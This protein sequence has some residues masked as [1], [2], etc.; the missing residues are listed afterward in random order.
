MVNGTEI[1]FLKVNSNDVQIRTE[2]SFPIILNT[3]KRKIFS[4]T[5][6][7]DMIFLIYKLVSE[8]QDF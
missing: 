6:K 5:R 1:N 8:N 4:I 7:Y 2:L 3:S